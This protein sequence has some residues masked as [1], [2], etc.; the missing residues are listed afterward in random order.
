MRAEN[1][2]FRPA[3]HRLLDCEHLLG[4]A[5]DECDLGIHRLVLLKDLMQ[6]FQS[7]PRLVY[8][9]VGLFDCFDHLPFSS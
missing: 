5:P 4:S 2:V 3:I 1:Q 6:C 9:T 7:A 8:I